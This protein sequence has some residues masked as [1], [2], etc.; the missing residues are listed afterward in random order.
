MKLLV[1]SSYRGVTLFR[2]GLDGPRIEL[3]VPHSDI[4]ARK[5]GMKLGFL[6]RAG[7]DEERAAEFGELFEFARQVQA[8]YNE[9]EQDAIKEALVKYEEA[10][11]QEA[12]RRAIARAEYEK[13]QAEEAKRWAE[14][15]ERIMME[16]VGDEARVRIRGYKTWTRY[17]IKV[18]ESTGGEYMLGFDPLDD[19]SYGRS[20]RL[21]YMPRFEVRVEGKFFTL[22]DDGEDDLASW[23]RGKL[24]K[25]R[26][27]RG[28][29][30]G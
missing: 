18:F 16:F 10:Q 5:E 24:P 28:E 20:K 11:R 4:A 1:R 8:L 22:W 27:L 6:D 7:M 17:R 23:E 3:T 12:E 30:D 19:G 14:R 2:D 26:L 15:R 13:R 21:E 29:D 9:A 25:V